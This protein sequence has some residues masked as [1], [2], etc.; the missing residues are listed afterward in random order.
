[1]R[2]HLI[3]SA[4]LTT[5]Q[6]ELLLYARFSPSFMCN[7]EH[8]PLLCNSTTGGDNLVVA[9]QA[10]VSTCMSLLPGKDSQVQS[11]TTA[12]FVSHPACVDV[13]KSLAQS[14]PSYRFDKLHTGSV[15]YR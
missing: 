1:M 7:I 11:Y 8:V 13:G 15:K 6:R 4:R 12:L 5:A 10:S 9:T 2:P 14:L 3:L